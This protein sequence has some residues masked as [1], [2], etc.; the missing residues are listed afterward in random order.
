M[1]CTVKSMY[2]KDDGSETDLREREGPISYSK[3]L[4]EV[5]ANQWI[6][7]NREANAVRPGSD[8]GAGNQHA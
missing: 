7:D 5:K 3:E 2:K 8:R 6:A 1:D 4:W